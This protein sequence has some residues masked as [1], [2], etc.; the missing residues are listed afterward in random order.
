MEKKIY[1]AVTKANARLLSAGR[2]TIWEVTP[3]AD[4]VDVYVYAISNYGYDI[5]SVDPKYMSEVRLEL[6]I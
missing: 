1:S 2:K 6:G 4:R 3:E 5:I